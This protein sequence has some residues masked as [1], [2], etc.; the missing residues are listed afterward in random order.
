[1]WI[2]AKFNR[3]VFLKQF[4]CCFATLFE[5]SA[6]PSTMKETKTMKIK[7]SLTIA[8]LI[9]TGMF[10]TG[11]QQMSQQQTA[12]P[13]TTTPATTTTTPAA[14]GNAHTHPAVPACT[15]S[16]TH[17]H[18]SNDPN[19]THHYSCKPGIPHNGTGPAMPKVKAKGNYKGPVS[20]DQ[21]SQNALKQYQKK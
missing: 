10:A 9:M 16:I 2:R 7:S 18:A 1:M 8:A 6:F 4:C 20:M 19:H 3:S 5:I 12:A 14:G 21:A 11:C 15:N 13:A 17:S